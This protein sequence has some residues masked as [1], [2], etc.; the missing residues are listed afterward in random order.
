VN[1]LGWSGENRCALIVAGTIGLA[2]HGGPVAAEHATPED[3]AIRA[4]PVPARV[5]KESFG[6]ANAQDRW[7]VYVVVSDA[8]HRALVPRHATLE[9][10]AKGALVEA[11]SMG[12]PELEAVRALTFRPDPSQPG[13]Q[14]TKHF[15]SMDEAFDLRLDEQAPAALGVDRMVYRV[16]LALPDGSL[17]ESTID[18]PVE[19]YS[20]PR[21]KLTF[22]LTG[23]FLVTCGHVGEGCHDERSQQFALDVVPVGKL[24]EVYA[25]GDGTHDE[26]FFGWGQEV[27]APADGVVVHSRN[28]VPDQPVP[29]RPDPSTFVNLD[30]PAWAIAGNAV[31]IDHGNGE[32]SLL[33]HMQRGS[34]RV[35]VGDHVTRGQTLGLVGASGNVSSPHLHYHLMSGPEL[36]RSDP[37]PSRFENTE[38]A[39][40][41]AGKYAGTTG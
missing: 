16:A 25:R 9:L 35:K 20:A 37:L 12:A 10:Y 8:Q 14:I 1:R 11:R 30:N 33:A 32:Y 23:D 17:V 39:V 3:P 24:G 21:T 6:D 13:R 36:F 19:E 26:D 4:A 7:V 15:V 18:L 40:P 31:V 22:P 38:P 29:H 5:H 34:V 2:C 41:R 27:H 28:D